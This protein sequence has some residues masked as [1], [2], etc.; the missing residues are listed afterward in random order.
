MQGYK[1]GVSRLVADPRSQIESS[2]TS[3]TRSFSQANSP[4]P[5]VQTSH[6]SSPNKVDWN[7]Q[8]LSSELEDADSGDGPGTPS[9]GQPMSQNAS[10]VS[11]D[12]AGKEHCDIH[13]L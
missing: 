1:S 5:T 11:P 10:S 4:F 12:I 13:D 7:G 9:L 6:A 8:A 2:Q 3:S